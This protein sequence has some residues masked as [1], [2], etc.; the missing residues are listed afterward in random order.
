MKKI[1][2]YVTIL[3]GLV[4]SL[5]SNIRAEDQAPPTDTNLSV[6]QRLAILERKYE[7]DQEA[8]ANKAKDSANFTANKD[9]FQVKS[10]DGN[11]NLKIGGLLQTDLRDFLGD[12]GSFQFTDQFLIRRARII[13]EGNVYKNVGFRIMPDFANGGGTTA[14]PTSSLLADAYFD[15]GIKPYAKIRA[16][17]FK[18]PV[19]LEQIQSDAVKWFNEG[20]LVSQLVPNRD[21]GLQLGGEL[22]SGAISYQAAVLDGVVDGTSGETDS[23]DSKEY[24]GRIFVQPFK[25][26]SSEWING[27]GAGVS[28]SIGDQLGSATASNLTSGYK[29][30]GQQTF[31]SYVQGT[32]AN[33]QRKRIDPQVYWYFSHLGLL[34]EYVGSSQVI[35]STS[36]TTATI[37]HRAWE[38]S[39]SYVLTGERPSYGGVKPRKPYDPKNHAWGAFE[40]VG[41]YAIFRADD[42][43]YN[44]GFASIN[45][46]AKEARSWSTGLN[47]YLNNNVRINS[48]YAVT[49]FDGGASSGQ[50]R[51]T[52]K[53]IL[54]R[55]QLSF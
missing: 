12:H 48:D 26:A 2:V 30:D 14:G 8:A 29:T 38:L 44:N 6:E 24:V 25:S 42:E 1:S 7:N 35:K 4:V 54:S 51:P 13:L 39:A 37:N 34:G 31:F 20:S 5:M 27:L 33:G 55:A 43:A 21:T 45:N 9:G 40:L 52:E 22:A 53:V 49:A 16:G 41:R 17:K 47:W 19:S 15:L 28:G 36:T 18:A 46:S 11:F 23:G 32:F 10:N 3:T 50:N